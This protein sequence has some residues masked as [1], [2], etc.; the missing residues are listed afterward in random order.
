MAQPNFAR[1]L[2]LV[3]SKRDIHLHVS[4][5]L[6]HFHNLPP[7]I[8]GESLATVPKGEYCVYWPPSPPEQLPE[9]STSQKKKIS[10]ATEE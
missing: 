6:W 3:S 4:L 10:Q 8:W 7:A 2:F 1:K 9:P 5:S